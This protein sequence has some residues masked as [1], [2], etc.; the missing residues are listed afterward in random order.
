MRLRTVVLVILVSHVV[1]ANAQ[2]PAGDSLIR[3]SLPG[4]VTLLLP[5]TWAPLSDTTRARVRTALD[6]ALQHSPDTLVQAGLRRG[7]PVL[8]LQEAPPGQQDRYVSFNAAPSPGTTVA[9]FDAAT[10]EEM[11]TTTS[12]MCRALAE[13]LPRLGASLVSCDPVYIERQAPHPIAITRTVR[14]G[15]RG[16]VTVWLAQ[17]AGQDAIYTLTLSTPQALEERYKQL[18]QTI[19]RSVTIAER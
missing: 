19:W 5:A 7:K 13:M 1:P 2:I 18:F 14:S 17:Y 12:S 6:T 8:M 11:A 4:S 10:P 3:R 15:P 16:F 9:S